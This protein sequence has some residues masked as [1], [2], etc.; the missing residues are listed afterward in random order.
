MDSE[1]TICFYLDTVCFY[2]VLILPGRES[3]VSRDRCHAFKRPRIALL[4]LFVLA[5]TRCRDSCALPLQ[6][7]DAQSFL[8]SH[9]LVGIQPPPRPFKQLDPFSKPRCDTTTRPEG[10]TPSPAP[11]TTGGN[12]FS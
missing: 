6:P 2:R 9:Q 8:I 7:Q 1:T 12:P 11:S 10:I 5:L 3:L 4:P